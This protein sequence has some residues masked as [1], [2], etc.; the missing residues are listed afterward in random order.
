[1]DFLESSV[2]LVPALTGLALTLCGGTPDM[3]SQFQCQYCFSPQLQRIYTAQGL[4]LFFEKGAEDRIYNL[5]EPM[6]THLTLFKAKGLW[7]LLGPYAETGWSEWAARLLLA[8]LGASEAE[9]PM[10]KAYR[11][12][13][14]I[15]SQEFAVKTAFLIAE[16]LDSE[17]RIVE[18]FRLEPEGKTSA[19]TFSD[20]YTNAEE[21]NRRYQLEDRFIEAVSM[22]DS[23]RAYRA[24]RGM[25]KVTSDLRFMSDS[26]QDQLVGAAVI[27]T[28]IRIGAKLGRLSPVLIDSISQEYAQQMKRSR[29]KAEMGNLLAEM[30]G[31]FC[32]EVR[33]RQRCGWSP[34]VRRAAE[35]IEVNLSKSMTTEEIALAAGEK[36]R[37]FVSRFLQETGMTVKEY[38]AKRRCNIAARLLAGS[39]TSIQEIAEYVGYTDNNYFS[40]VFKANAGMS[41]QSY[42]AVHKIRE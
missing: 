24:W 29:S 37:S 4:E 3:L 9:L 39:E 25:G 28:L 10:Y 41:P 5:E 23:V 18:N 7:L 22:G 38:L 19:L 8:K 30:V 42:R 20:T 1:M 33:E 2:V 26:I 21:V 11:C 31:R 36:K 16:N 12:K 27:R 35:Y 40:K 15:V 6:G 34:V 14:P 32:D 17:M 13:L